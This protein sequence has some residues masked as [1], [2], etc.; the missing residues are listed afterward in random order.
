[1]FNWNV[2]NDSLVFVLLV[3]WEAFWKGVGLWKSAKRSE[4]WWFIAI[5]LINLFGLIP[6]FYLW[7]TKQ[8]EEVLRDFFKINLRKNTD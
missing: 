4:R 3:I 8:L 2:P 7:R 5:F 6:L 1:M